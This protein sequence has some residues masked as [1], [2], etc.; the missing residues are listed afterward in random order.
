M[1]IYIKPFSK[2]GTLFMVEGGGVSSDFVTLPQGQGAHIFRRGHEG[3]HL[4][5][6]TE[7]KLILLRKKSF[8]T[9]FSTY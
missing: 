1:R 2:E 8:K 9:V 6:F 3:H 7:Q 4:F 5:G